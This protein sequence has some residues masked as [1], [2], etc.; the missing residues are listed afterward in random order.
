M[1]TGIAVPGTG[2]LREVTISAGRSAVSVSQAGI[3][4]AERAGT[5]V[6]G[7]TAVRFERKR[8]KTSAWSA[9]VCLPDWEVARWMIPFLRS[10][11]GNVYFGFLVVVSSCFFSV[12][13]VDR[14]VPTAAVSE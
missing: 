8:F 12:N 9:V 2:G 5:T 11:S 1:T 7:F 14:L 13:Q 4:G 6:V 3:V 10:A